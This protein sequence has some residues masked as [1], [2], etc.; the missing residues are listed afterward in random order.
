MLE[1]GALNCP[2]KY[3][4]KPAVCIHGILWHKHSVF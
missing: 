3:F 2:K 1:T 4:Q